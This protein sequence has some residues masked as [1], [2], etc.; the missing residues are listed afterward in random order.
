MEV[1]TFRIEEFYPSNFSDL[2]VGKLIFLY[3]IVFYDFILTKV[4]SF[5]CG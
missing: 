5:E 2:Y 4:L 1:N 3:F